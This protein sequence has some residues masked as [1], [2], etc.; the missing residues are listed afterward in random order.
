MRH[1]PDV[2]VLCGSMLLPKPEIVLSKWSVIACD[3]FTSQPDYWKKVE[4]IIGEAPSTYHLVLPEAFL[5]KKDENKWIESIK[6]H[7]TRYL[8]ENIFY[9]VDSMIFIEREFRGVRRRGLIAA[10]D[11]EQYGFEPYTS[12]LIRASEETI[13]NR[14]PPRVLIRQNSPIET[15][16]TLLLIDDRTQSI[17]EPL[18]QITSKLLKLYEFELM[19]DSGYI[20]GYAIEDPKIETKIINGFRRLINPEQYSKMYSL[21][22]ANQP[23]L[24]AVG[25]GNHS[26]A[27]A[28]VHWD[29]IKQ[30]VG[31][32]HPARFA[33]VEIINLHDPGLRIEP[34]HR[35][36]SGIRA[37]QLI[38]TV[39]S[40][41]PNWQI[42]FC[43]T[44]EELAAN[45][46]LSTPSIPLFGV[47]ST[48]HCLLISLVNQS[49]NHP[50]ESIQSFLDQLMKSN[51]QVSIDFIHDAESIHQLAQQPGNL[52]IF[53]PGLSKIDLYPIILKHGVLPRKAFSMGDARE[54]RFYLE[55]R[56]IVW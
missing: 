16:H 15:S 8:Q 3:Q 12:S 21:E 37:E 54:K 7:A 1:Y 27:A 30:D 35:L 51:P 56:K 2:G 9:E 49:S 18:S 40:T 26:L 52:G 33:M 34:I 11:L 14:L 32:N 50:I 29:S 41:Q 44:F 17:I 19:Q 31:Y 4:D 24:F 48:D 25:D 10:I 47:F 55:C 20:R 38:E 46:Q 5:G 22:Q 6:Q 13:L 53:M 28:K 23:V 45:I 43:S 36:L 42:G 39:K